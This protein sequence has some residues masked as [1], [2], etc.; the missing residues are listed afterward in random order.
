MNTFRVALVAALAALVMASTGYS[1]PVPYYDGP[2]G[3]AIVGNVGHDEIYG[4]GGNDAPIHGRAGQDD[5]DG[6][7]DNDVIYL[8]Q[9]NNDWAQGG[10]GSDRIY[11]GCHPTSYTC[12]Q[13]STGTG[14]EMRG[15]ANGDTLGA[16]NGIGYERLYCGNG[17]DT[18]FVDGNDFE[19]DCEKI[20]VNGKCVTCAAFTQDE[21]YD[22][23][24][25]AT[26]MGETLTW[27]PYE[28][29]QS[30]CSDGADND[31]DGLVDL[32]EDGGC[33]SEDDATEGDPPTP[34]PECNDGYDNDGDL[35]LDFLDPECLNS[36][37]D[38]E[39]D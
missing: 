11:A 39:E 31:N 38:S 2:S 13:G 9:G 23:E 30:E 15:G 8:G 29:F 18:A 25:E 24:A 19:Y 32:G 28:S 10:D 6:G 27:T 3:G 12:T 26:L 34:E 17:Q 33:V 14:T 36:E 20:V 21:W 16:D 35:S 5:I 37:D 7:I 22:L 4:G 1:L